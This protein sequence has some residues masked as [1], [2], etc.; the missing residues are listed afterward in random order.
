M[1]GE[2]GRRRDDAGGLISAGSFA[3]HPRGGLIKAALPCAHD[4]ARSQVGPSR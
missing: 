1:G 2:R 4:L 3:E